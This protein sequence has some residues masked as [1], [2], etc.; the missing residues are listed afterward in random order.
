M[1]KERK[2]PAHPGPIE[3]GNTP[4]II[5]LT[6]C[7]QGRKRI[8]AATEIQNLLVD[9]WQMARGWL[10]GR[11][12]VMPDHVHLFCAPAELSPPAL[13]HWVRYWKNLASRR[14]PRPNEQPIW[15]LNFWDTQLRDVAHYDEKW[16]YTLQNPVRAGLVTSPE[17]WPFSGELNE[18]RW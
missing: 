15:Q 13:K 14:W 18:L 11:Y 1:W 8:L 17:D 4:I 10:V 6:V 9:S 2:H 5:Y 16:E 12:V 3:R 7:T